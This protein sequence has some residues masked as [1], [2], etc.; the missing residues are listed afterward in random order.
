MESTVY[1][2]YDYEVD[3]G[4]VDV[5][6]RDTVTEVHNGIDEVNGVD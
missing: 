5:A 6:R 4:I 1:D 2:L 3:G